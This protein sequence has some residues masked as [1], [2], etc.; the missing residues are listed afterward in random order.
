[1][2]YFPAF[3][4]LD[5]KKILLVGGG[6]IAHEKLLHLLDFTDDIFLIAK[7]FD[8]ITQVTIQKYNLSFQ[9]RTYREKEV[10]DFDIVVVAVDDLNL[11]EQI[12]KEAQNTR[13]L[14]NCVDSV[15]YCDF[16]FPS[17]I[18]QDDLT[19]AISTSGSSPSFAK[20]FKNYLKDKIP[21]DI[22]T[23]LQEMKDLRSQFPKGKERM[24]MFDLKVKTYMQEWK[25]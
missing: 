21:S 7:D 23:F 10:K 22:G 16:I 1:M 5:N 13:C 12:Y 3:F 24:K 15:E 6:K 19:I 20:H 8:T 17:Y 18:K 11:Q 25:K 14:C 2:A 9:T 4:K